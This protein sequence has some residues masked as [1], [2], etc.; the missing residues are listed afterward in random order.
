[1]MAMKITALAA[2]LA[3]GGCAGPQRFEPEVVALPDMAANAQ[4]TK[5]ALHVGQLQHQWWAQLGSPQLNRLMAE[6]Q[7]DN[8][9]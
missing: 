7:L 2:M 8:I 6:A 4:Q 9:D 1:M 5:Q 3:A